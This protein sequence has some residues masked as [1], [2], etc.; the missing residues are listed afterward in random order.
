MTSTARLRPGA[1]CVAAA[2]LVLACASPAA[3]PLPRARSAPAPVRVPP[4]VQTRAAPITVPNTLATIQGSSCAE[5]APSRG[6]IVIEMEGSE[7]LPDFATTATVFL[8]GWKLRYLSGDHDVREIRAMIDKV[9]LD[10]RTLRWVARGQLS[11]KNF[12]DSF[13]FCY[14]YVVLAW[15][16]A[17]MDA[18][19]DNGNI[20]GRGGTAVQSEPAGGSDPRFGESHN[21]AHASAYARI[22]AARGKR[23]IAIL[24]RGFGLHLDPECLVPVCY[25]VGGGGLE[26]DDVPL[27]QLSYVLGPSERVLAAGVYYAADDQFFA[28]PTRVEEGLVSWRSAGILKNNEARNTFGFREYTTA[29]FGNDVDVVQPPYAPPVRDNR[30][31]PGALVG[32][33]GIV[34][35]EETVENVPFSYIIPMLSGWELRY[36]YNDERVREVGVWVHDFYH[37]G[38]PPTL[39]Y[40][41]SWVLRDNDD[42]PP[43]FMSHR[44]NILGLRAGPP[45][46]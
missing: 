21:P 22:A 2:C 26:L 34:T 46:R 10:G 32:G 39:R 27:L 43:A 8:N 12:D 14:W 36:P 40:K 5:L 19:T 30:P 25:Q 3:G 38:L 4:M 16:Q 13:E 7:P 20:L 15:N 23:T 1:T 29:L 44:V 18:A 9:A 17:V 41:L 42:I 24:P 35:T 31:R 11:D 37:S 45:A 33:T 28:G 6:E